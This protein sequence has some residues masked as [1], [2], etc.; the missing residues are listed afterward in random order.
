VKNLLIT[1]PLIFEQIFSINKFTKL[2]EK[3]PDLKLERAKSGKTLI[4]PYL[5]FGDSKRLNYVLA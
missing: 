1:K 5:K 3:Y 4:K 2:T